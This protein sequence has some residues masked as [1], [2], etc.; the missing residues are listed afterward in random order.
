[1]AHFA[2]SAN[3]APPRENCLRCI[4]SVFSEFSVAVPSPSVHLPCPH[5]PW[6]V[7]NRAHKF[8]LPDPQ[9][10]L[11]APCL[12]HRSP[13][14][15]PVLWSKFSGRADRAECRNL[16]PNISMEISLHFFGGVGKPHMSLGSS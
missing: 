6:L 11:L 16:I 14:P 5:V 2:L 4:S 9:C 10:R 12:L 3:S 1:M 8:Q 7:K 15:C 13:P